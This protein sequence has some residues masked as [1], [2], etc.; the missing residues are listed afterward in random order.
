[1]LAPV[2]KDRKGEHKD[3]LEDFRKKGFVRVRVDGEIRGLD[4]DI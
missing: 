4:E 2:V 3:I 1:M